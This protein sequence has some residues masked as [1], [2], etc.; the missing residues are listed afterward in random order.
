MTTYRKTFNSNPPSK[1]PAAVELRHPEG[2]VDFLVADM[3]AYWGFRGNIKEGDR[4]KFDRGALVSAVR[5]A[6][7]VVLT[8]EALSK[9]L[10]PGMTWKEPA[11]PDG[12]PL[13]CGFCSKEFQPVVLGTFERGGGIFQGG[14]VLITKRLTF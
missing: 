6:D 9:C 5:E 12:N 10:L 1:F 11:P 4:F 7:K 3:S 14:N 2:N 13:Q 8:L